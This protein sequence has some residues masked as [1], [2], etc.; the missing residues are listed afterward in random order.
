MHGFEEHPRSDEINSNEVSS[1]EVERAGLEAELQRARLEAELQQA[2]LEA[3]VQ[4]AKREAEVERARLEAELQR[5]RLEAEVRRAERKKVSPATIGGLLLIVI[6]VGLGYIL[7]NVYTTV[8]SNDLLTAELAGQVDSLEGALAQTVSPQELDGQMQSLAQEIEFLRSKIDSELEASKTSM[9]AVR[10]ANNRIF[11][12]FVFLSGVGSFFGIATWYGGR[13]EQQE[14]RKRDRA[15][16]ALQEANLE[17]V[18]TITTAIAAGAKENVESLNTILSTFKEIMEFRAA[19]AGKVDKLTQ[20]VEALRSQLMELQG[21]YQQQR[22]ELEKTQRQRVEELLQRAVRLR[23]PRHIYASPDPDLKLEI[24]GYR[25]QMDFME[26]A[27]LDQYTGVESPARNRRYGE[28]Y[29]RRGVIAYYD[30]D[31]LKSREMLK[32]A[33]QFFPVSEQEIEGMSRDQKLP[34]AFTQYYLSLIEKNYGVMA[35]AREC[36]ERSYA[37]YGRNEPEELLTPTTR[38]EILSYLGDMDNARVAIQEVLDRANNLEQRG[39]LKRHDAIYALRA[40]LLLGNTYYVSREWQQAL[41]HYRDA[42]K[43]DVRRVYSYYIY[44]SIAQVHHKQD[45]MKE[46]KENMRLAYEELLKTK[47]LQTKVALDTL[48]L[49]NALAY[50]CTCED[51][52]ETAKLY[53][54]TVQEHLDRIREVN[55]L[56]LRLFSFKKKQQVSKDEFLAEV[57]S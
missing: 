50:L 2:R 55:G 44:H 18:N 1:A 36:I 45:N 41:Q 9:E 7:V 48:I 15:M 56:E 16:F 14:E 49:L 53:K 17:E 42:L 4:E 29:L 21:A 32:I 47:H 5:A 10:E 25:T 30:N 54:E 11:F 46:A 12:L 8:Y 27:R 13:Q 51:E 40:R 43:A 57:F 37:V 3:E 39:S 19:E 6:F 35:A 22:D 52:P 38:A 33:E 28:I 31:V 34:I 26:R 23:H 20:Q 24:G